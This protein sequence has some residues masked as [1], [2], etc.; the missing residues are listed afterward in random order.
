V[1][2]QNLVKKLND[3]IHKEGILKVL[4]IGI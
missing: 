2:K 4:N 3:L 1:A